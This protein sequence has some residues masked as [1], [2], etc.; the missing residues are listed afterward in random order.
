M[1]S[2]HLRDH[3]VHTLHTSFQPKVNH[4]LL[5]DNITLV[6]PI[7]NDHSSPGYTWDAGS[8]EYDSA[9]AFLAACTFRAI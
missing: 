6:F 9:P 3:V 7:A 2:L 8:D 4:L 5:P 1:L